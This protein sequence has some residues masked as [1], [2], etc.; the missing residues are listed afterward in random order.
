MGDWSILATESHDS[1]VFDLAIGLSLLASTASAQPALERTP[2]TRGLVRDTNV[3][4]AA[5]D[6]AARAGAACDVTAAVVRAV[7]HTGDRHYE[8]TYRD[9][10]GYLIVAGTSNTAYN[11]LLLASQNERFE[12]E[13]SSTRQAPICLLRVNRNPA[14]HLASMAARA[15]MDCRVDEG[16]VVGLS[17]D[18]SPIYEIG[19][20]GAVGAWIE[21][22]SGGWVVTDCLEIRSRGDVCQFTTG[23]EELAGF[24]RW[25]AGS[26]AEACTPTHLRG[27]GRNAA[28]FTYFEVACAA[29]DPIVVSLD[30][31]HRVTNVLSCAD[32]AHIGGGCRAVYRAPERQPLKCVIKAD[33]P[34]AQRSD[35]VAPPRRTFGPR[36]ST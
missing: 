25:L 23:S 20:R 16:R 12:R 26:A 22:A 11:C 17:S 30:S 36:L 1:L 15:G 32:A 19:C 4:L 13:G 29:G 27:M 2:T 7:G 35:G 5:R 31:D 6:A 9:G 3:L 28:E 10:P 8:V 24:R 14:R 21:Q 18:E 33:A 34:S